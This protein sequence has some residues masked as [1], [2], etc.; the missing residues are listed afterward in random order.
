MNHKLKQ[1]KDLKEKINDLIEYLHSE[2]CYACGEAAI[3]IEEYKQK[4]KDLESSEE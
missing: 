1:I 3:Q 4:I 2:A